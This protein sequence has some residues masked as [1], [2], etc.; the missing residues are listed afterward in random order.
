MNSNLLPKNINKKGGTEMPNLNFSE[1]QETTFNLALDLARNDFSAHIDTE[2]LSK[3]DLENHLRE[4]INKEFLK[5]KTLYQAIR[6]NAVTLYEIIEEIVDVAI[7]ENVL[8]SPFI[9]RF[10]ECRNVRLG[11][12]REFYSEG[13]LYSVATFAGNHWD[14]NRQFMDIGESF[15]LPTEWAY[16]HVYEDVERFLKKIGTLE[17]VIDKIYKSMGKFVQDRIA[18]QFHSVIGSVPVE[19]TKTGN[20]EKALGEVVDIV[21]AAG[22]YDSITIAG[23]KGALR[24]LSGIVPDKIFANS[25]K[26]A[27][28][29]NGSIGMWEGNDLLLIPQTLKSGTFELA[30]SDDVLFILD[31]DCRPIKVTI[32]GD[33]R[34]DM[35]TS[36]RK[37]NDQSVDLQVQTKFGMGLVLSKYIGQFTFV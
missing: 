19:F 27:N 32:E 8:S 23:T 34:S 2:K 31:G 1:T 3:T 6:R 35:D 33:T 17:K 11:D 7:Q 22:G 12:S 14:T 36:I 20:D 10:V 13:G 25:Q 37:N 4:T 28:A 16:L 9:D 24:K 15:T 21:Q 18:G 30:L 29:Q 5:G 26:E